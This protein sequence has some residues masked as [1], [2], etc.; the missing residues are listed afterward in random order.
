ML[1]IYGNEPSRIYGGENSKVGE[2]NFFVSL[3]E[4]ERTFC[5]AAIIDDRH[6]ITAA[7]CVANFT[8]IDVNN[9]AISINITDL[10]IGGQNYSIKKIFIHRNYNET[11]PA[12][13]NDVT[14]CRTN[15]TMQLG[16]NQQK[17]VFALPIALASGPTESGKNV[18]VVGSGITE[19]YPKYLSETLKKLSVKTLAISECQKYFEDKLWDGQI[20]TI[21][22]IGKGTCL[23]DSGGPV[24]NSEG[25]LVGIISWGMPCAIDYPDVHTNVSYFIDWI[26]DIINYY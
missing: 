24:V 8:D 21:S 11:D 17:S 1:T 7:H 5:G 12:S 13:H 23:G 25:E 10:Q 22:P 26:T 14:I 4:D 20:C 6:V 19:S 18:T 3:T 15:E 9:T 16:A 2:H